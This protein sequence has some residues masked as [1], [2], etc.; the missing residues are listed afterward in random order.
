MDMVDLLEKFNVTGD[1]KMRTAKHKL[2]SVMLG[3]TP[4]ALRE[5]DYLRLD[6]KGKV[7][8]L[9]KELSW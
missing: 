8:S 9:I 3:I 2:E 7:D 1:P 4:D 5:D 6:V